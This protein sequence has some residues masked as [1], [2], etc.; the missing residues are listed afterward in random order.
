[1][2]FRYVALPRLSWRLP[3]TDYSWYENRTSKQRKR[4][5]LHLWF[6]LINK[7]L[8]FMF[9]APVHILGVFIT[10]FLH[11]SL[12]YLLWNAFAHLNIQ[13]LKYIPLLGYNELEYSVSLLLSFIATKLHHPN[14]DKFGAV[15]AVCMEAMEGRMDS[16][17]IRRFSIL[18][19]WIL[20]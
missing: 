19:I 2:R 1:M 14:W 9:M 5:L 20:Q 18:C 3:A 15:E 17:L 11:G 4:A 16:A 10:R 7:R 13:S 6:D 12:S 8:K